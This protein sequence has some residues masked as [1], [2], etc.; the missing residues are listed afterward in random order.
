MKMKIFFPGIVMLSFI[1]F[2]YGQERAV[3]TPRKILQ[4][5]NRTAEGKAPITTE[6]K[7]SSVVLSDIAAAYDQLEANI[8]AMFNQLISEAQ[9]KIDKTNDLIRELN[10]INHFE[11]PADQIK[12][13][14]SLQ[15]ELSALQNIKQQ[16]EKQKQNAIQN[17]VE[18]RRKA[19]QQANE[20]IRQQRSQGELQAFLRTIK[21][22]A[23]RAG[24][25][26]LQSINR[27]YK[28]IQ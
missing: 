14:D 17:L 15:K 2:S 3:K 6:T 13:L 23:E 21:T 7:D 28:V 11:K 5:T 12:T 10:A 26:S 25:D 27:R 22:N 16:L 1:S 8:Q 20:F 19:I 4:T 24:Q 9:A 18:Q